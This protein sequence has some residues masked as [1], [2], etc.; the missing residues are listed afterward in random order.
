MGHEYAYGPTFP[1]PVPNSQE[2]TVHEGWTSDEDL[3]ELRRTTITQEIQCVVIAIC[4]GDANGQ[5]NHLDGFL[6]T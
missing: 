4:E 2:P 6:C 1:E 5:R 3:T